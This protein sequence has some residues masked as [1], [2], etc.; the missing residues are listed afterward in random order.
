M[1][2]TKKSGFFLSLNVL[3]MFALSA[4][5]APT[6]SDLKVTPI[7]PLGLAIDYTVSGAEE[8]HKAWPLK[9]LILVAGQSLYRR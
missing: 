3:F 4:F 2:Y 1:N 8:K 7:E 5:A 9:V 6:I